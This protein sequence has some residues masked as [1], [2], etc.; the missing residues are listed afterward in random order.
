MGGAIVGPRY[1]C[2]GLP[3]FLFPIAA[4][5]GRVRGRPRAVASGWLVASA[6]LAIVIHQLIAITVTSV[7]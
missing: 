2:A 6:T 4:W 1:L 5:L 7:P 3:F